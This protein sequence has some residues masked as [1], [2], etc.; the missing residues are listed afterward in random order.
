MRARAI[1]EGSVGLL[2][3]ISVGLFGALVLWLR[4]ISPG[5]R[6]YQ[7]G[8]VFENT[9]GMQ[10]GTVVRYR[11]V[12]VGRVLAISPGANEVTVLTEITATNLRIPKAVEAYANQSGLI[13]DTTIDI[14]P[15]E[16]LPET[17][18]ALTPY[19]EDCNSQLI[20]CDGDVL[21]GLVGASYESLLRSAERLASTYSDPLLV[22][23]LRSTL[24]NASV[25][26]AKAG[27]VADELTGLSQSV[28]AEV[29]PLSASARR[30]ADSVSSAAGQFELTGAEVNRLVLANQA[31]LSSTLTN[32]NVSSQQLLTIMNSLEP[33]V[34]DS[35]FIANLDALSANALLATNS[36]RD[37]TGAVSTRE[38][39]TVLQQTLDSARNVFQNAQ[40]VL[41]DVDELTGDPAFRNNLRDLVNGLSN[42]V[43]STGTLEQQVQLAQMLAPVAGHETATLTLTALPDMSASQAATVSGPLLMAGNGQYYRLEFA[44]PGSAVKAAAPAQVQQ[45]SQP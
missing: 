39:L 40:K 16:I 28:R 4:G 26:A 33:A 23:E 9:L 20:V 1:R 36:L 30:A 19:D 15:L 2:I 21:P 6:T 45:L 13:G 7:V 38:N 44:Q 27:V 41:A 12:P 18:L 8:F 17:S 14:T 24:N 34:R 5:R 31:N 37:L 42:L 22:A 43:S 35:Q 32:L 25:A 29:Q 3:L 11:G 10:A